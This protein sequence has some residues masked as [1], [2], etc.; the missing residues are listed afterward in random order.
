M[1]LDGFFTRGLNYSACNEDAWSEYQAFAP[2]G[3]ENVLCIA[4]GGERL[5]NQL[6]YETTG[7]RYVVIDASADQL[8][9]TELKRAAFE[10]LDHA[11]LSRFLGLVACS[12]SER[13]RQYRQELAPAL[14][15]IV[16]AYWDAR[17][18]TIERGVLYLGRFESFVGFMARVLRLFFGNTFVELFGCQNLAEQRAF[19]RRRID[20]VRWKLLV[21]LLCRK[22]WFRLLTGDPAFYVNAR[23]D[24]YPAHFKRELERAILELPVKDNFLLALVLCGRYLPSSGTVPICYQAAYHERIRERLRSL[25][26]VSVEAR[27]SDYLKSPNIEPFDCFSLSD[28]PSYLQ[29][30]EMA[31]LL[32]D[33]QERARPGARIV[34]RQLLTRYDFEPLLA[35]R[36]LLRNETLE[37]ALGAAPG[38][39]LWRYIV[40]GRPSA[41]RSA[42]PVLEAS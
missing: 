25:E 42:T 2:V 14:P 3:E 35:G 32:G 1:T 15:P 33:I 38:N 20:G 19:F 27:V 31:A 41:E 28:L 21:S 11:A 22:L 8:A 17:P 34:I 23:I 29:P 37:R 36:D 39:L 6:A 9:L 13:L 16:R 40:L 7:R 5:F 18:S 30:A 12:G 10:V 24:S 26:F 4:G